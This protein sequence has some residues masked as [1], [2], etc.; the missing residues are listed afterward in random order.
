MLLAGIISD[1][2]FKARR[3]PI[4]AI[5]MLLLSCSIFLF[6]IAPYGN[7]IVIIGILALCGFMVYGPLMLVSVAA[8]TYAGKRSAASASGFTGFWG[9][10]GATFSGVGIGW[11]AEHYGWKGAFMLIMI[12]G[13]LSACFFALTWKATPYVDDKS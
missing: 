13:F 6:W 2:T 1:N 3:G 7:T 8:A 5:Y 9:Y 4:M 12:S 10:V 11:A